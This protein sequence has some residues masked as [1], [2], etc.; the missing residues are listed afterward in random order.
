MASNPN[1]HKLV[2]DEVELR[3]PR[4]DQPY[5]F[6]PSTNA[7]EACLPTAANAAWSVAFVMPR[8]EASVL[9]RL[10][11]KHFAERK[12]AGEK[13]GPFSTVFG[14]KKNDDGT[15][16][17]SA[18]R[19]ATKGDGTQATAPQVVD[20]VGR[21][22][23]DKAIWSGS[24]GRVRCLAF[25]SK[26][27]TTG[28]YGI[29]LLLD[30]VVVTD[31]VYGGDSLDDFGITTPAAPRTGLD[32]FDAPAPAKASRPAGPAFDPA[33]DFGPDDELPFK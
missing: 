10:L 21:E 22:L 8:D 26:N 16:T 6:N 3:Y 25:P 1:F 5:R 33:P 29:S 24:K 23:E 27:G 12:A 31:P 32:D 30:T 11:Q 20:A 17:F 9:Y 14:M 18:K 4:L 15:V 28:E 2:T 7:S 13:V 19:K